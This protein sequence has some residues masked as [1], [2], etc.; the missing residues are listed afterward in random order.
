MT[1]AKYPKM[2][3]SGIESIGEIPEEWN[4]I[5][6]KHIGKL[7]SGGTPSTGVS[8]YWENGTIPWISSGEVNNNMIQKSEKKITNLG[9]IES[10]AKLFP[11]NSIL[12]AITGEGAT[13]GRTSVLKIDA[14]TN[15]SVVGIVLDSK[16]SYYFFLWYYIQSQYLN[17]RNSGHGSVQSGLNLNILQNYPVVLQKISEQKQIASYL[18]EKTTKIDSL[19]S[20]IQL[21][22]SKL[23]EFRESLISSAVTGKICV[24]N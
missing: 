15:Q 22:I 1:F 13:R 9:L 6:L 24:T 21:Q 23:E 20:K 17:L 4:V 18:D 14:T 2:K 7:N 19:I 5:S 3:E 12:I 8:A 16:K 11:K 10:S